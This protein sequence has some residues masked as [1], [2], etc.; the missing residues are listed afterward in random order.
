MKDIEGSGRQIEEELGEYRAMNRQQGTSILM[1]VSTYQAQDRFE[2]LETK[3]L[4]AVSFVFSLK[5]E[6]FLH[7]EAVNQ[8]QAFIYKLSVIHSLRWHPAH[9]VYHLRSLPLIY[10]LLPK[11]SSFPFPNPSP[12]VL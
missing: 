3:E 1:A 4:P 6:D 11:T 8:Q 7:T 12:F 5:V 9:A 10:K 2:Y